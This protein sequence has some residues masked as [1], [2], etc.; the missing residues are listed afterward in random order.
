LGRGHGSHG[1]HPKEGGQVTRLKKIKS[2]FLIRFFNI[3][4][5]KATTEKDTL[6]SVMATMAPNTSLGTTMVSVYPYLIKKMFNI[7]VC[8]YLLYF[9]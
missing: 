9:K 6:G 4:K 2:F 8:F 7:K 1:A 5:G 3:V